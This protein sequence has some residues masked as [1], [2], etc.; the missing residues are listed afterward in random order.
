MGRGTDNPA[1][2]HTHQ[3]QIERKASDIDA[4]TR[5]MQ[6]TQCITLMNRALSSHPVVDI[7][8][9]IVCV[10]LI[11]T[12]SS[13]DTIPN[14]LNYSLFD[15][16][17]QNKLVAARNQGHSNLCRRQWSEP[18]IS[19]IQPIDFRFFPVYYHNQRT[20]I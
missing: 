8:I 2:T 15:L 10:A 5:T 13:R 16:L 9:V 20:S 19:V 1:H 3:H 18:F 6:M 7:V 12:S 11:V 14:R 17:G 4:G